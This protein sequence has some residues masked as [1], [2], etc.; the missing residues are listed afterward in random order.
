MKP[1]LAVAAMLDATMIRRVLLP[2][3]MKLPRL[4]PERAP[5]RVN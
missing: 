1:N 2:V 5:A 4:D 3:T